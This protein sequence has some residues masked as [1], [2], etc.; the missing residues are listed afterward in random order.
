MTGSRPTDLIPA[1]RPRQGTRPVSVSALDLERLLLVSDRFALFEDGSLHSV[2]AKDQ[3]PAALAGAA[4]SVSCS[5]SSRCQVFRGR[6]PD[7]RC[8][9]SNHQ[10]N[11]SSRSPPSPVI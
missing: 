2:N 4:K 8:Q 10:T 11:K 9:A 3:L 7:I 1:R 5:L 6:T